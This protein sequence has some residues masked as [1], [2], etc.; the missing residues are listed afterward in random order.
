LINQLLNVRNLAPLPCRI[1][2]RVFYGEPEK[3]LTTSALIL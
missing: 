3:I 1:P 2:L